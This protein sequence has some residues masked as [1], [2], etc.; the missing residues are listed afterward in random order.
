MKTEYLSPPP[1]VLAYCRK[2]RWVYLPM[3]YVPKEVFNEST[4]YLQYF[5]FTYVTREDPSE[6]LKKRSSEVIREEISASVTETILPWALSNQEINELCL[7]NDIPFRW[8][9]NPFEIHMPQNCA[10]DMDD[11]NSIEPARSTPIKPT[12]KCIT[13]KI[14]TLSGRNF[15]LFLK[16]LRNINRQSALIAQIMWFLNNQLKQYGGFLTLQEV[17]RL[18]IDDIDLED[19]VSQCVRFSRSTKKC[20]KMIFYNL[21]NYIWK[22]LCKQIHPRTWYVFSNKYGGPLLPMQIERYFAKAGKKAKLGT[23]VRSCSLRPLPKFPKNPS[24]KIQ[25][26]KNGKNAFREVSQE[27]WSQ[28]TSK[29]FLKNNNNGRPSSYD[30]RTILNAI[31]YHL[32]TGSPIRKLP[33]SYPP[34]KAVDSQYRRWQKNGIFAEMMALLNISLTQNES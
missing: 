18:T 28:I 5:K 14:D 11:K 24:T 2:K 13:R 6:P 17:V 27:E 10:I 23:Y 16:Q 7:Q 30:P 22:E 15:R 3:F 33:D 25:K 8:V 19:E 26:K 34:W 9:A 21:P 32:N 4:G 29:L 12:K 1:C 31:L 20:T